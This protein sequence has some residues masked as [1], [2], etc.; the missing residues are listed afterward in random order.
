MKSEL[1][2]WAQL[3]PLKL[4]ARAIADGV[5]AGHHKSRRRG[6]G[7]EF[8]GHREYVPGDDLR[9]LDRRSVLRHGKYLIREY[10]METDRP[11]VLLV[12]ATASMSYRGERARVSKLEYATTLAAALAR[13]AVS[14]GDLVSVQF[15]G[16]SE[17]STGLSGG[18]EGF[19]RACDVLEH[20]APDGD[21]EL[22]GSF[23][24]RAFYSTLRVAR[25]G[26]F[27]VMLSDFFD[28]PAMTSSLVGTLTLAR[29]TMVCVQVVDR[30]EVEF[31]FGDGVRLESLEGGRAV[32]TG[33]IVKDEYLKRLEEHRI[34]WA[35]QL[36]GR[37]GRFLRAVTD[38]P[39]VEIVRA[40]STGVDIRQ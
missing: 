30:D 6:A 1:V 5:Y 34:A 18:R 11:L 39:P 32:E 33:E 16:G 7:V 35:S 40:I 17:R 28:L 21:G 24:E 36:V 19:E 2:D 38:E 13:I 10:D 15:I 3:R 9:R 27:V 22:D 20:V 37:G 12:D 25:R 23:V 29:R 31:P 8:G 26:A 14:A 4:R